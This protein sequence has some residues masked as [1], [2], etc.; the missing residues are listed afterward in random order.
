MQSISMIPIDYVTIDSINK[1]RVFVPYS[2][3]R[4]HQ[5]IHHMQIS[6]SQLQKSL[7]EQNYSLIKF[8]MAND[9]DSSSTNCID[10]FVFSL[11]LSP[12][13]IHESPSVSIDF[14]LISVRSINS[15]WCDIFKWLIVSHSHSE[16]NYSV[17]HIHVVC[18]VGFPFILISSRAS[19]SNMKY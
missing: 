8:K 12:I 7:T 14:C 6:I 19:K 11:P 5:F 18:R 1:S 10:I 4:S 2:A 3:P 13:K 9:G 15:N 16:A 17:V